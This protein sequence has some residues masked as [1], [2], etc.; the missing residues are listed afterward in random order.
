MNDEEML[1]KKNY[2]AM[3]SYVGF[4]L[5]CYLFQEILLSQCFKNYFKG[6]I[7]NFGRKD[8]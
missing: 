5:A 4:Y 6:N 8:F 1:R 2:Y 7:Q 3:V